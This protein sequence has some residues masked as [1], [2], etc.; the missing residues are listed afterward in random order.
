MADSNPLMDFVNSGNGAST[1]STAQA[2]PST[3][4]SAPTTTASAAPSSSNP[5]MNFVNGGDAV[6]ASSP[7]KAAP[8]ATPSLPPA[9][10]PYN[11]GITGQSNR[12]VNIG[13]G[14]NAAVVEMQKAN[15]EREKTRVDGLRA[16]PG[17][18]IKDLE[19]FQKNMGALSSAGM[20][21]IRETGKDVVDLMNPVKPIE[22]MQAGIH[23]A[24]QV[25]G[26]GIATLNATDMGLQDFH[27]RYITPM[28]EG[29]WDALGKQL[30]HHP[31]DSFFDLAPGE[32]MVG[33]AAKLVPKI[34]ENAGVATKAAAYLGGGVDGFNAVTDAMNDAGKAVGALKGDLS[35]L[36]WVNDQ[37]Q[38]MEA[39]N[40]VRDALR[41]A[42]DGYKNYLKDSVARIDKAY[43][44]VPKFVKPFLIEG[45]EGTNRL[46]MDMIKG[47]K[48]SENFINE[49]NQLSDSVTERLIKAGL[50][51]EA[52]AIRA[53]YGPA[54]QAMLYKH[55]HRVPAEVLESPEH[56]AALLRFKARLDKLG[57]KP[58]YWGLTTHGAVKNF[59]KT[60]AARP[61]TELKPEDVGFLKDRKS[62]E[63]VQH[64]GT[65]NNSRLKLRDG[66]VHSEDARDVGLTRLLQ[67]ARVLAIKE[68]LDKIIANPLV[69][70][71]QS[72]WIKYDMD[73]IL[74]R[75]AK[76]A[77]LMDNQVN[78]LMAD[79]QKEIYL[80]I[81][82]AAQME[83]LLHDF[84]MPDIY[85]KAGQTFKYLLLGPDAIWNA[86]Q[87]AQNGLLYGWTA[88]RKPQDIANTFMAMVLANKREIA[89]LIPGSFLEGQAI[90]V[91]KGVQPE[92]S[93][94]EIWAKRAHYLLTMGPF[95]DLIDL[96]FK[97]ATTATNYW[98]MA[99]ATKF[100][101]D[102]AGPL[103]GP[104]ASLT[105]RMF[106]I[107][108][109]IDQVRSGVG[110]P[111]TVEQA[112]RE[113]KTWMGD[114][115]KHRSTFGK[116]LANTVMFWP[117]LEHAW[118]F[119]MAIPNSTPLKS[120]I[121][122]SITMAAAREL[123]NAEMPGY[124]KD[125]GA[126]PALDRNGQQLKDENGLPM[127]FLKPG[128]VP[129]LTTAD[130]VRA[131][132][133]VVSPLTHE[134]GGY[135]E[136][137]MT[138]ITWNP[139]LKAF[140]WIAAN[141]NGSGGDYKD[142]RLYKYGP[143]FVND[144]TEKQMVE[145]G[146]PPRPDQVI[147]H[148]KP[149]PVNAFGQ[150]MFPKQWLYAARI[151]EHQVSGGIPTDFTTPGFESAPKK[152]AD[153]SV[154][155]ALPLENYLFDTGKFAP[156]QTKFSPEDEAGM[157]AAWTKKSIQGYL[158]KQPQ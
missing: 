101:L 107:S 22:R 100:F 120:A 94:G 121:A 133:G 36:P 1:P 77:G 153:G 9:P 20:R 57:V 50:L 98:R 149:N 19:D 99:T 113:V 135:S 61:L 89:D 47:S 92:L 87:F 46:S 91:A 145:T 51:D 86:L 66:A 73:Q 49:V 116:A 72:G 155:K 39:Y 131:A 75:A 74:G 41:E 108:H 42:N 14:T 33:D 126:V 132:L 157:K 144:A 26:L 8:T 12:P 138:G 67:G 85:G 97:A 119:T 81:R 32:K 109:K 23:L 27:D 112:L 79:V 29:N 158:M 18:A 125:L 130:N 80:P 44:H 96:N 58:T 139:I 54:Y 78:R 103:E 11:T 5:L 106:S 129:F 105:T 52:A 4:T 90:K 6:P 56:T 128:L 83:Q 37:V 124:L 68:A 31:I 148:P 84:R 28:R 150:I 115:E 71:K 114:Y 35:K 62:A 69:S 140:L 154:Q 53:R 93:T 147:E 76:S 143:G 60:E 127:V 21:G 13:G 70:S 104:A 63:I 82:A 16:V 136:A 59:L 110:N 111:E 142:P 38:K 146:E 7:T 2:A 88:L 65:N 123:Q 151:Y 134:Q 17:N 45:T 137:M 10:T 40:L 122:N 102:H 95:R 117:W 24:S 64:P 34:A 141:A 156:T 48:V 152:L 3:P 25:P 43:R 55:G 118:G 30:Q 15:A